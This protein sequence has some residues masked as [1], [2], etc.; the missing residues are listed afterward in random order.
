MDALKGRE[1]HQNLKMKFFVDEFL[2]RNEL[3]CD[4]RHRSSWTP[5][6]GISLPPARE[7]IIGEMIGQE[8]CQRSEHSRKALEDIVQANR[9]GESRE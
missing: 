9:N 5:I 6:R 3:R 8:G 2:E 4:E 1:R 7:S